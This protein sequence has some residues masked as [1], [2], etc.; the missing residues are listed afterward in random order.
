V[1]VVDKIKKFQR[2]FKKCGGPGYRIYTGILSGLTDR[3]VCE[4]DM[5]SLGKLEGLFWAA[6]HNIE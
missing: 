1:A 3:G 6:S 2:I 5:E 4:F